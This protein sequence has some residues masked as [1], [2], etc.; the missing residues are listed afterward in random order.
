MTIVSASHIT[1]SSVSSKQKY[2]LKGSIT[3]RPLELI[4]KY[5][6][7]SYKKIRSCRQDPILIEPVHV[8]ERNL[9]IYLNLFLM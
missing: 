8:T 5:V 7:L 6:H 1:T 2:L 4:L 3:Q 9:Y